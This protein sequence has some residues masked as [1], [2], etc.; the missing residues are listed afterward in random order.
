S[1]LTYGVV[2]GYRQR[3]VVGDQMAELRAAGAPAADPCVAAGAV[4][5]DRMAGAV[6]EAMALRRQLLLMRAPAQFG[7]L[8]AFGQE[9]V[10]RPGVDEDAPRLRPG[11]DLGVALGDMDALHAKAAHQRRPTFA[12]LRIG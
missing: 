2:V 10:H 11:R 6:G 3:L 7:R 12:A 4:D 5:P 1:V 9:A 8:E